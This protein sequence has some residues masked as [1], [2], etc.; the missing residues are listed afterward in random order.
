MGL[1]G[2][3][4]VYLYFYLA[5]QETHYVS[6]TKP[7]RLMLFRGKKSLFVR[8]IRNTQNTLCAQNAEFQVANIV[9]IGL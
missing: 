8:T 6:A 5:S 7:N 3:L 9:T 2:L 1:H 4:Q